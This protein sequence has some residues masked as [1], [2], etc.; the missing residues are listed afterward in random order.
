MC[1]ARVAYHARTVTSHYAKVTN[2]SCINFLD[3]E[4]DAEPSY[5]PLIAS[6]V[7]GPTNDF[8]SNSFFQ[9]EGWPLK[10]IHG[11]N[12]TTPLTRRT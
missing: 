12:A 6:F 5:E 11:R 9:L 3:I 7:A 4:E 8:G 10:Y 2:T 1:S